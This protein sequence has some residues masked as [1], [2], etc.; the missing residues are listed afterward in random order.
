MH[1]PKQ[2]AI[3]KPSESAVERLFSKEGGGPAAPE[4]VTPAPA[5]PP[6][7][8]A[9]LERQSYRILRGRV[10]PLTKL[11]L[12]SRQGEAALV[13][14]G[15]LT[16]VNLRP[17]GSLVLHVDAR[18]PYT[19]TIS[20]TGLT[21][22]LLDGLQDERVEFIQELEEL[23]AAK[24]AKDEPGAGIVT[25]IFIKEGSESREW[26]RGASSRKPSPKP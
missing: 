23:A 7:D 5:P 18:E 1:N 8:D 12:I 10:E 21:G 24:A 16:W 15:I 4:P 2:A 14:Y 22:E 17:D 13:D 11:R 25:G 3:R 20:G 19:I 6:K 26:S 9:D